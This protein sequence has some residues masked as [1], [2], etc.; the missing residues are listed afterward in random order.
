MKVILSVL[1][2]NIAEYICEVWRQWI[3]K[4]CSRTYILEG[5]H[6]Q[7]KCIMSGV[8]L[9]LKSVFVYLRVNSPIR[10][11]SFLQ[12]LYVLSSLKVAA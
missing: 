8:K 9:I 7:C 4:R 1:G 11:S 3:K 12:K 5:I 2:P 6:N 10:I